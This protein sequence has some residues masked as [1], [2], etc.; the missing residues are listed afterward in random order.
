M[1]AEIKNI[2]QLTSK[3]LT[4]LLLLEERG[5]VFLSEAVNILGLDSETAYN[6]LDTIACYYPNRYEYNP[7]DQVLRDK[8]QV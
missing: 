1:S 4:I 3:I 2:R 8:Y 5:F 7:S 6:I